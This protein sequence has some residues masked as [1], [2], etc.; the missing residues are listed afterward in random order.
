MFIA[1]IGSGSLISSQ[2]EEKEKP[3]RSEEVIKMTD[4]GLS[5]T[6]IEKKEEKAAEKK[7][8]GEKKELIIEEPKENPKEE[9][10]EEGLVIKGRKGPEFR[11]KGLVKN[12]YSFHRTDYYLGEN[13]LTVSSKNLSADL[14]RVRLS[15]EFKYRNFLT[16]AL[17]YDNEL[18]WSNLGKSMDFK[19]YWRPRQYND[20]L[21]LTWEPYRGD[22]LYYR[23]KIHRAVVKAGTKD[24][25]VTVG[26]QQ[27]RFGSG[28]LWN[29]LD[30]LNPLSPVFIEAASEQKGTDA[31]RLDFFPDKKSEITIILDLK[32]GNDKIEHINYRDLNYLLRAKTAV[33]EV[34][35][36]I[37][38]GYVTRR[39][40]AGLDFAA[41]VF[42]GR[43]RGSM[44]VSQTEEAYV[45]EI[46]PYTSFY[47]PLYILKTLMPGREG[48][49]PVFFQ[50]HIGY[51]YTFK[52]GVYILAEYFFNQR[53]LNY[54]K[55]SK[56]AWYTARLN[57]MDQ[58]TYLQLANQFLTKNQHYVSAALGY[59]FHPM[60][61][62]ELF[63]IGDIQG[64][65]IF[66]NPLLKITP[67]KNLD[68]S[69]GMMGAF[70]FNNKA[71]DFSEY[72]KNYL[73]YASGSYLF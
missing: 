71:S 37:L 8:E 24:F 53:A 9:E 22:D 27:I 16:I 55:D 68:F 61:R 47:T 69:L 12:L 42:D 51:E 17:D 50:A 58:K 54:N 5:G 21:H 32:R 65:G 30:I 23:T 10:R 14:T 41:P 39:G 48:Y 19:A 26:R 11:L 52:Q 72:R 59:G 62:G 34:D 35:I 4:E 46:D 64:R 25:A 66:W 45:E 36:A 44:V 56:I 29:P 20:F 49:S 18:I 43:L 15:P 13:P 40:V 7:G 67:F 28:R 70:T 1:I 33:A 63:L 73:F 31:V 38:G 60:V 2:A 3:D 6:V 57:A